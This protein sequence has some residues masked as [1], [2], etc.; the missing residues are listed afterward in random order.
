[1]TAASRVAAVA[2]TRRRPPRDLFASIVAAGLGTLGATAARAETA[3]DFKLLLYGEGDDR[4]QVWNPEL[5][6]SHDFGEKGRLGVLLGYDSISGA[7]PTGE[8]PTLDATASASSAGEIPMAQYTDTRLAATVSYQ[9]RFGSHLPSVD[10][11]YSRESDY[12][13]RGVGASDAWTLFGGR[14]TLHFGAGITRDIVEPVTTTERFDKSSDSLSAGWTQILGPRDLLDVSLSLT[15]LKGY[16]NDPY[17][18]V[19]VGTTTVPEVRPDARSRR[20][21]VFKYGHHFLSRGAL[22]VAYRWYGDDWSVRAH[23]LD[24]V[25]DQ[26]I[27]G[28]W[29]LT[30]TLRLY[31]QQGASFYAFEFATPQTYMSSDYRLSDFWS[32]QGGIGVSYAISPQL[33]WN[34]AARFLEQTGL[35]R[36]LPRTTGTP[37]PAL[38]QEGEEGE[39]GE[40]GGRTLSPADLD[41]LTLTV[42]VSYRF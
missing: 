10:L 28:K 24:L 15:N 12:L 30:P 8:Y 21:V 2:A 11:S 40:E 7:S 32:W 18:V 42:G 34:V 16:L 25:Y 35:D 39:E 26:R 4:T 41:Q 19:P 27:G 37:P 6:L 33:S 1:M 9:K 20:T 3:L 36:V 5:Y 13:S 38:R 29:I 31:S 22:K 17:K 23:T 14:S